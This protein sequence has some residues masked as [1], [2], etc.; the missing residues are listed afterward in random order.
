MLTNDGEL[1]KAFATM[2]QR[3][4]APSTDDIVAQLTEK[5]PPRRNRVSWPNKN[6][7]DELRNLIEKTVIEM[8]VD[9]NNNRDG[10]FTG[11]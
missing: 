8:D 6:R 2:V 1:R 3:G 4:V 5:F 7:I 10:N 11:I 9:E